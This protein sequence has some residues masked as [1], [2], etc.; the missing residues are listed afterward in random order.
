L[1]LGHHGMSLLATATVLTDLPNLS[2]LLIT[3]A[4]ILLHPGHATVALA[5]PAATVSGEG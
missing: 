3:E 4:K 2:D 1:L 5:A